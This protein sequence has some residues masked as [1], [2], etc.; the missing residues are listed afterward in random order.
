M[1]HDNENVIQA[2]KFPTVKLGYCAMRYHACVIRLF[3]GL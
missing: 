2:R 1:H 3:A